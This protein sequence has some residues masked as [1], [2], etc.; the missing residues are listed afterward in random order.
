MDYELRDTP[1]FDF[2]I[3]LLYPVRTI[4]EDKN[5]TKTSKT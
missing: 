1:I 2:D 4:D 5:F 3:G